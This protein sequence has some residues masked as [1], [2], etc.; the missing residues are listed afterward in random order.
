MDKFIISSLLWISIRHIIPEKK[1]ILK[2]DEN[3]KYL[4]I[5]VEKYLFFDRVKTL[6]DHPIIPMYR[7]DIYFYRRVSY[8]KINQ[9]DIE[10][11]MFWN[12][13]RLYKCRD[14]Y[15]HK[16]DGWRDN[17]LCRSK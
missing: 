17:S 3:T 14:T 12:I 8:S 16:I 1:I 15:L 7:H 5:E 2:E 11:E 13:F 10:N 6:V 9:T 4:Y